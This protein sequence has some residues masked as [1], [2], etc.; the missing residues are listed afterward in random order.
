MVFAER[1][2]IV[3]AVDP[4]IGYTVARELEK[5]PGAATS[6]LFTSELSEY[7]I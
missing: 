1:L 7:S 5:S 4:D 6:A 3:V 2:E